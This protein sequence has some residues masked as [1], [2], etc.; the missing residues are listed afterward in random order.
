MAFRPFL[1]LLRCGCSH[2][3]PSWRVDYAWGWGI[4]PADGIAICEA[5]FA[6]E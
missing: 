6:R 3:F 2:S 1:C 4:V 5:A